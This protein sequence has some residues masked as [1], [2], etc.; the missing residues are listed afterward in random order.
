[1]SS[2]IPADDTA[3]DRAAD[4]RVSSVSGD[5]DIGATPMS[6]HIPADD[7][8]DDRAAD[9]RVSSVSGDPDALDRETH[10]AAGQPI[11]SPQLGSVDV[12]GLDA[13]ARLLLG[14]E[15][16]ASV[17]HRAASYA[18]RA[19]SMAQE[20]SVSLI[21]GG[22]R[23]SAAWTGLLAFELDECQHGTGY[24]PCLEAA[25]TNRVVVIEDTATETRW[26]EFVALAARQGVGSTLSV[27]IDREHA[28]PG[29]RPQRSHQPAGRAADP[30]R[31]RA[32][33]GHLDGRARV[34]RSV[35]RPTRAATCSATS[36][37]LVLVS[38]DS[39]DRIANA[40]SGAVSG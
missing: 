6:S 39:L 10:R 7:T 8:A 23:A 24:G 19:L 31:H 35:D 5:P 13:L 17:L 30:R 14:S 12:A 9:D 38:W 18:H 1:M 28:R 2:H 32:G 33:Q 26:P 27:P 20:V 25:R 16:I 40:S 29:D 22:H 4:D 21:S 11:A 37:S 3:D 36:R 15:S 34:Q